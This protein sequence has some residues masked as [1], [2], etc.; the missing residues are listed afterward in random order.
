MK[1]NAKF[2]WDFK[3]PGRKNVPRG[4]HVRG[5]E[6]ELRALGSKDSQ[7]KKKREQTLRAR[8]SKDSL[9]DFFGQVSSTNRTPC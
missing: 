8:G 3:G 7:E 2:T 4:G 6:D 1:R 5:L 9:Q